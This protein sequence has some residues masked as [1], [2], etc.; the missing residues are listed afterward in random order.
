MAS[1]FLAIPNTD[2]ASIQ[3]VTGPDLLIMIQ[4]SIVSQ[5]DV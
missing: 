2:T 5:T 4:A 1:N 3:H